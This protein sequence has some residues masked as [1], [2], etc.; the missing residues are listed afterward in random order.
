MY[1]YQKKRPIRVNRDCKV[2]HQVE[3]NLEPHILDGNRLALGYE[4][5]AQRKRV[6]INT[7]SQKVASLTLI[8]AAELGFY[9]R[10]NI[11]QS[12]FS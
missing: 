4:M 3:P 10:K 1:F 2:A 7:N 6:V 11:D 9:N 12:L 5:Q 8:K